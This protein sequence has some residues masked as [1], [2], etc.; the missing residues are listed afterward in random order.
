MT[1]TGNISTDDWTHYWKELHANFE[2]GEDAFMSNRQTFYAP[3]LTPFVDALERDGA[4]YGAKRYLNPK[5]GSPMFSLSLIVPNTG[6]IVEVVSESLDASWRE[7]FA[8]WAD[9]DASG[10]ALDGQTGGG[11]SAANAQNTDD[12]G[13]GVCAQAG[14]VGFSVAEMQA[15]WNALG[16]NSAGA[17]GLPDLL[18]VHASVATDDARA[19]PRVS[20]GRPGHGDVVQRTGGGANAT[21]GRK[22][23]PTCEFA[24]ARVELG[25]RLARRTVVAELR[26]V[27]APFARVGELS[28]ADHEAHAP[29]RTRATSGS[30]GARAGT[31]TSTRTSASSSTTTSSSTRSS[32]RSSGCRCPSARTSRAR[33]R[34]RR[35]CGRAGSRARPASSSGA[36]RAARGRRRSTSTTTARPTRRAARQTRAARPHSRTAA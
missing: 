3:A 23:A 1:P 10:A 30:T 9:D 18:L 12:G 33:S 34:A 5:D 8:P 17:R 19:R 29:R 31:G 2:Q 21:T 36:T 6:H 26:A 28:V 4:S 14:Y 11:D 15:H 7:K 16:G 20:R 35:A 25:R 13:E 24:S 32:R 27:R 22:V